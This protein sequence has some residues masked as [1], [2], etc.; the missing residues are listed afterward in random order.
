MAF[1]TFGDLRALLTNDQ[2]DVAVQ[3]LRALLNETHSFMNLNDDQY[4]IYCLL[5]EDKDEQPEELCQR[6]ARYSSFKM[7][8]KYFRKG[9][10]IKETI[11]IS[12]TIYRIRPEFAAANCNLVRKIGNWDG[13]NL[14]KISKDV[15]KLEGIR[16]VGVRWSVD[17]RFCHDAQSTL[18]AVVPILLETR[19]ASAREEQHG[20]PLYA[21][22]M[23]SHTEIVA[24]IRAVFSEPGR[25]APEDVPELVD[26]V[27]R[28]FNGPQDEER[29]VELTLSQ[30]KTFIELKKIYNGVSKKGMARVAKFILHLKRENAKIHRTT[31]RG[32]PIV[33]PYSLFET[34]GFLDD[35]FGVLVRAFQ[36][37]LDALKTSAA[38]AREDGSTAP[39]PTKRQKLPVQCEEIILKIHPAPRDGDGIPYPPCYLIYRDGPEGLFVVER[40]T[41]HDAEK[42]QAVKKFN[43]RKFWYRGY[44][45]KS[46]EDSMPT[47][48]HV[49]QQGNGQFF[50]RSAFAV[51]IS[52][53]LQELQTGK[54][55][56]ITHRITTLTRHCVWCDKELTTKASIERGSGDV[57]R[58]KYGDALDK[59]LREQ[60]QRDPAQSS[61]FLK[62]KLVDEQSHSLL[63][64]KVRELGRGFSDFVDGL[65]DCIEVEVEISSEEVR[66]RLYEL[67]GN[68][69]GWD[70]A[71]VTQAIADA[72]RA[73][74][75]GWTTMRRLRNLKDWS[76]GDIDTPF[77][78]TTPEPMTQRLCWSSWLPYGGGG[79]AEDYARL[80][81]ALTLMDHLGTDAR[82]RVVPWLV[83]Q[84]RMHQREMAIEALGI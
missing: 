69:L 18:E 58:K 68:M 28:L 74:C 51:E 43:W 27:D 83:Q 9:L 47:V 11:E 66:T 10:C 81:R 3:C 80:K 23:P 31:A 5:L 35:N 48:V 24:C 22:E 6:L 38:V 65:L 44:L 56:E 30:R 62:E 76:C 54:V 21:K 57:C 64:N 17:P 60:L 37:V 32:G 46:L 7:F 36:N 15:A 12:T 59:H 41:S 72:M 53:L 50:G 34:A 19:V 45:S 70:S 1:K 77:L 26:L 2:M 67:I 61:A 20:A 55:D 73:S 25:D 33:F 71:T 63:V 79:D 78:I 4:L 13:Y 75:A 16:D 29:L 8:A 82:T 40:P 84:V 42:S 14:D 49:D 52:K 39:P